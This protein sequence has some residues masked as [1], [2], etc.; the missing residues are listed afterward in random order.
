MSKIAINNMTFYY[1]DYFHPVF[2][3]VSLVLDTDWRLGLIGRNGRGKST[4]LKLLTGELSCSSGS[5]HMSVKME[6]FPYRPRENYTITMD[7]LK[8]TIG[9]LK[10]MEERMN[11]LLENYDESCLEEYAAIQEKYTELSGYEMEGRI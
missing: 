2:E 5:I 10:S 7:V 4:F 8:E 3:N 6:Y 1:A 11:T 9:G